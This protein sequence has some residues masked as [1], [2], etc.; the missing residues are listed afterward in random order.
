MMSQK[1]LGHFPFAKEKKKKEMF[2]FYMIPICAWFWTLYKMGHA[3]DTLSCLASLIQQPVR[4]IYTAVYT[5][6]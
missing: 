2:S 6:L 3:G 4:V 1:P 5:S